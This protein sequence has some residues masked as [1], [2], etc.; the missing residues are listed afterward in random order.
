LFPD[1]PWITAHPEVFC[2]RQ[3]VLEKDGLSGKPTLGR[4]DRGN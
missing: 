4:S 2:R 3:A 1:G